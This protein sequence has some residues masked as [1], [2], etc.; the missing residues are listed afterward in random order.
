MLEMKMDCD[1]WSVTVGVTV[2]NNGR[3]GKRLSKSSN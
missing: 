2:E 1:G 3:E